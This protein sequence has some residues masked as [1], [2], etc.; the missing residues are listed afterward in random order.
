MQTSGPAGKVPRD[1]VEGKGRRMAGSPNTC[2]MAFTRRRA[3]N[4]TE[5]SAAISRALSKGPPDKTVEGHS[6]GE[7]LA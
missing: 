5:V 1:G 7:S 6:E 4:N 3:V 2:R